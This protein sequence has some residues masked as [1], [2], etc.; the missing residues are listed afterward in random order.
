M[1]MTRGTSQAEPKA[2]APAGIDPNRVT[3]HDPEHLRYWA[4]RLGCTPA[5]LQAAVKVAGTV[6]AGVKQ[7]LQRGR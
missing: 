2:P 4:G 6:P 5:R 1:A 7:Y 3:L